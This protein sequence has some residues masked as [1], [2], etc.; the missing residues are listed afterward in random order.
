MIDEVLWFSSQFPQDGF[1]TFDSIADCNFYSRPDEEETYPSATQIESIRT[2]HRVPPDLPARSNRQSVWQSTRPPA[3]TAPSHPAPSESSEAFCSFLNVA[4][5]LAGDQKQTWLVLHILNDPFTGHPVNV[6]IEYVQEDA[7][8]DTAILDESRL[9][10]FFDG[11]RLSRHRT[12][13]RDEAPEGPPGRDCERTRRR[14]ASGSPLRPPQSS[15]PA[16]L[17]AV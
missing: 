11:D 3:H 9:E 10:L 7:D 6:H 12:P 5:G 1:P 4:S 2:V 14:R 17:P 8:P 15:S 16:I 13:R